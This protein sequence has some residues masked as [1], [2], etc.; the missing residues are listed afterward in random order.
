MKQALRRQGYLLLTLFFVF[1]SLIAQCQL[2]TQVSGDLSFW[3]K[4]DFLGF[5]EV[6]DCSASTGDIASV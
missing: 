5:D 1:T 2:Q 3:Q 4:Q 6:K